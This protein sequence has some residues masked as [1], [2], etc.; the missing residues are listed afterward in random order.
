MILGKHGE[1]S[2]K[3][4]RLV[5]AHLETIIRNHK[6]PVFVACQNFSP[7]SKSLL[8][9]DN[10]AKSHR[11]IDFIIDNLKQI[12]H[13]DIVSVNTPEC[14]IT[15]ADLNA[16]QQ[17]M[18]K[19]NIQSDI[20]HTQGDILEAIDTIITHHFYDILFA[21]AYSHS[22]FHS[23]LFGSTTHNLL[24]KTNISLFLFPQEM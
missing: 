3:N 7:L 6:K 13:I 14:T 18:A 22:Q 5:G 2:F 11:A 1:N 16:I 24:T 12:K 10:S 8:A 23:V 17:K 19:N 15:D 20:I 9:F 4:G 21:G